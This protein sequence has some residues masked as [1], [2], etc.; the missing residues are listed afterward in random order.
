VPEFTP[1]ETVPTW[2][3]SMGLDA[4]LNEDIYLVLCGVS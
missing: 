2:D 3:N 4:V 1:L